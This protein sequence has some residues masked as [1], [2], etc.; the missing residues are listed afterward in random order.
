ML[1]F[2]G[3]G[4]FNVLGFFGFK[5]HAGKLRQVNN[6]TI[7]G[8]TAKH[9]VDRFCFATVLRGDTAMLGRLYARLCHAFLFS[10]ESSAP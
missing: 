8:G 4:T 3:Y 10:S 2:G 1:R 6:F 5:V 9:G 7:V